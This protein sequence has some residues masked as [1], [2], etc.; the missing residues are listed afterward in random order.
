MPNFSADLLY[1]PL[2]TR[3]QRCAKLSRQLSNRR[4]KQSTKKI[5][6][7]ATATAA[8]Q[9]ERKEDDFWSLLFG[10]NILFL[11]KN[12]KHWAWLRMIGGESFSHS[13][14]SFF[15]ITFP[16]K[17]KKLWVSTASS[18]G[19]K[20]IFRNPI[21]I[22]FQWLHD[23]SQKR[24]YIGACSCQWVWTKGRRC[25]VRIPA[26]ATALRAR[27][28]F[29]R[30]EMIKSKFPVGAGMSTLWHTQ[31]EALNCVLGR[32]RV[33]ILIN[34]ASTGISAESAEN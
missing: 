34:P 8:P 18:P 6:F 17:E 7:A 25:P 14:F 19:T 10:T 33:E 15:V 13:T 21:S 5:L 1:S 9:R 4:F 22:T 23:H 20:F 31:F 3:Q 27:V 32:E 26:T 11:H 16:V 30:K 24:G 12:S 29:Q 2:N 28:P